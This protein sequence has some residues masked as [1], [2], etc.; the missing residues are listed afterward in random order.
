LQSYFFKSSELPFRLAL[1]W[2]ALRITD[3]VAPVMAFGL[4]R[5]RGVDGREG[6][7]WLFLIEGLFTMSLG[8]WSWFTMV[9]GPTQTKTWFNKKGWF[10]EREEIIMVNRILRDDPSKGDMHNRQAVDFKLL[11]ESLKDYDLWPIYII[12]LTFLIPGGPPD[13]YLTLTLRQIGF[14][15]FDANL[16]SIPTQVI[17]AITMLTLTYYS[18]IFNERVFMGIFSQLWLL[19]NVL[20]LLVLPDNVGQWAKFAVLTVLLSYPSGELFSFSLFSFPSLACKTLTTDA[21]HALHV[22]WCSRNSN[23]VRTRTVSAALY[24]MF[25][26]VGG[27]IHANIYRAPDRPHCEFFLLL[28]F[29]F[30]SPRSPDEWSR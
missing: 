14:N 15:T 29:F 1:F 8:I 13:A 9:A 6:W 24:N 4:L 11:W 3:V 10:N 22:G 21:A 23:T 5:M 2:T 12:G 20:A 19:P 18:E 27:I 16:L 26:Q 7:R 17:G 28:F 25:V 30:F